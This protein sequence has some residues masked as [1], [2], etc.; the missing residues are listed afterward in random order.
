M[1]IAC[2]ECGTRYSVD[3]AALAAAGGREV[4][5]AH[6]GHRWQNAPAGE[7]EAV[8]APVAVAEASPES[9]A[10]AE[11]LTAVPPP[12]LK[13]PEVAEKVSA[14]PA[15]PSVLPRAAVTAE[16]K[17]QRPHRVVWVAILGAA[18]LAAALVLA[19]ILG[20]D[21]IEALFPPTSPLY[22][23]LHLDTPGAGLK[24]T[25]VPIRRADALVISGDI[26]NDAGAPRQVPRLRLTLLDANRTDLVSKV[27]DPPVAQLPAGAKA[28]F[29]TVFEHPADAAVR[30]NVTYAAD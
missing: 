22:A 23:K 18:M 30:V 26:V 3:D 7:E 1:I 6:C 16:R 21:R 15:A 28:H 24:V 14:S 20:R 17:S 2:P 5:C 25:V 12:V 8:V 13:G 29:D 10:A 4:R 9:P 11:P 27:I 19:V